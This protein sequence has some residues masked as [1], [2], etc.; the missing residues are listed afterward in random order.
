ME[1]TV[2]KWV[3]IVRPK[4][5]QMPHKFQPKMSAQAKSSRFLKKSSLWVSVDT[6]VSDHKD[7]L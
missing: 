2:P 3:L 7:S 5:L 4:I 6:V 1:L